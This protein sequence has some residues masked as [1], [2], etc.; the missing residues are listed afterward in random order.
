V[1]SSH[2][3]RFNGD[4]LPVEQVSWDVI[5]IFIHA[6]NKQTGKQ[7]RLPSEAEW[8]YATRAG[9]EGAFSFELPSHND[10]MKEISAFLRLVVHGAVAIMLVS[11]GLTLPG[12]AGSV[13]SGFSFLGVAAW[14]SGHFECGA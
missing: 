4:D 8:E 11:S 14:L 9:T 1:T 3:S 7:F 13:V 5:Q 10:Y 6:L 2:P 12:L